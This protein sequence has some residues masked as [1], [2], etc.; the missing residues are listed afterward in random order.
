MVSIITFL[1]SLI[2]VA[3]NIPGLS[4][5]LVVLLIT[6]AGSYAKGIIQDLLI[7]LRTL[8]KMSHY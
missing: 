6:I 2:P 3:K 7:G 4:F 1:I 8:L 5:I